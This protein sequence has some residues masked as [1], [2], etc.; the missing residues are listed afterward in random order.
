MLT[1]GVTSVAALIRSVVR[2]REKNLRS[3]T[4]SMPTGPLCQCASF[5]PSCAESGL[6]G[7]APYGRRDVMSSRA[8]KFS[9]LA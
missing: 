7:R 5:N 6:F 2:V 4:P 1:G 3:S 9:S 8:S